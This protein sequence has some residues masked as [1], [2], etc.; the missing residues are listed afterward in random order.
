MTI[1]VASTVSLSA[2]TGV[3]GNQMTLRYYAVP[4][5]STSLTYTVQRDTV[6]SFPSPVTLSVTT[7]P[8][9]GS[10]QLISVADNPGAEPISTASS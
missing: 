4:G 2:D 5:G 10:P 8:S 3:A 7:I 9:G 1:Q 6:V